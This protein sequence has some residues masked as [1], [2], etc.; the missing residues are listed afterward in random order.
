MKYC[1][2]NKLKSYEAIQITKDCRK[3]AKHMRLRTVCVYGGTGISEQIAELKRGAE[4]GFQNDSALSF[5]KR[6]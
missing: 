5:A 6:L 1:R 4:V 3:F 2:N